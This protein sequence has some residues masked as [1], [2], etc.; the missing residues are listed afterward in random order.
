MI[1]Y[2]HIYRRKSSMGLLP[3][4]LFAAFP[5]RSL[6]FADSDDYESA[7]RNAVSPDGDADMRKIPYF[8]V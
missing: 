6:H 3:L 1:L 2:Y 7:V 8:A 5:P 4:K